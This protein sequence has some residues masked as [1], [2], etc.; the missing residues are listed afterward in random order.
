MTATIA[1][2]FGK[3]T[4]HIRLRLEQVN[5]VWER[6]EGG[7]SAP[8]IAAFRRAWETQR[9]NVGAPP[10]EWAGREMAIVKRLVAEHPLDKLIPYARH[11]WMRYARDMGIFDGKGDHIVL[12]AARVREIAAE[13]NS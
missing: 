8:R 11:F 4:W 12:F 9:V 6:V 13:V 5:I 10:T 3:E 2:D 7:T 1:I